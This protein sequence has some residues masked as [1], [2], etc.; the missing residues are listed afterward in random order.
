M[1]ISS[2]FHSV[3]SLFK[4]FK[5]IKDLVLT[6]LVRWPVLQIFWPRYFYEV[7]DLNWLPEGS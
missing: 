5:T 4:V 1:P 6:S 2:H 3:R 7:E